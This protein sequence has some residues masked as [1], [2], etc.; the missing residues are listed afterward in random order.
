MSRSVAVVEPAAAVD[1]AARKLRGVEILAVIRGDGGVVGVVTTRDI[2][3]RAC[4][5]RL[6]CE[7]TPVSEIMTRDAAACR[8]DDPLEAAIALMRSRG[9]SHVLVTSRGRPVGVIGLAQVAGEADPATVISILRWFGR[10]GAMRSAD[11]IY[12][13][14]E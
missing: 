10:D 2:A 3:T 14:A 12:A 9:V 11:G 8:V 1:H 5:N 7:Q 13:H 6:A 4:A